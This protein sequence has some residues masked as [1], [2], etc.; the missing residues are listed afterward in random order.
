MFVLPLDLPKSGSKGFKRSQR[1]A[2]EI[3][4]RKWNS[5]GRILFLIMVDRRSLSCRVRKI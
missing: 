1:S 4:L 2:S 5:V 3:Q